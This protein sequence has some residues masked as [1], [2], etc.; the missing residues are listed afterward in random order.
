MNGGVIDYG[1]QYTRLLLRAIRKLGYYSELLSP[2]EKPEVMP[3]AIVLSGGPMS[4]YQDEAPKLPKW[5]LE[6]DVPTLGVCYGM[7][8]LAKEL[9]GVVKRGK[10]EYGKTFVEV[11][12]DDPLF[13]GVKKK[14][15][16]WMSHGDEV[17]EAPKGFE[18]LSKSSSGVVSVMRKGKIVA[19]QFHPEVHHT[20]YGEILLENFFSKIAKLEKDWKVENVLENMMNEI[21]E[22]TKGKR[23]IGAVS[24][25]VDS[26]V[27]AVL[28]SKAVGERFLG[29][30][31]DHGLLR[32]NERA[33]VEKTLKDLGVNFKVVDASGIFLERLKGVTDSEEKRK[34]IGKTFI[35]VFEREAKNWKAKWLLQGTIYSDVIESGSGGRAS[36]IKSHHNVGGLPERLNLKLLEPFRYLFKDEVREIGKMLGLPNGIVNRHP[37]PGPG[38]AVRIPGEVTKE[39]VRILQDVDEIFIDVLRKTGWYE[40]VWQAFSIL[41]PVR[42][43]GVKGDERDYG[44]AV[45][46]RAVWSREGMTAEWVKFPSEVLEE[47]STAILSNVKEVTRVLYDISNKPPATIEWE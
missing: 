2:Y 30:F 16:V 26:T 25:G 40:K 47:A 14:F 11:L 9:G 6:A 17:T 35:D 19:F 34:I 7:Q 8:L 21:K 31:V 43:T 39:K 42:T 41:L 10:A 1:S 45:V 29:V 32:K 24:G 15:Q 27:A 5:V 37:F 38:L 12:R 36:K 22:K 3:D 4:V 20:Q 28:T 33:T 13:D 23:V 44:Y 46:L 18:V